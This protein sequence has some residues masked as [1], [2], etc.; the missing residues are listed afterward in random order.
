MF[1]LLLDFYEQAFSLIG[2]LTGQCISPH[3]WLFLP[4]L[5][6]LLNDDA[7]EYFTGSLGNSSNLKKLALKCGEGRLEM[8]TKFVSFLS[9]RY[10]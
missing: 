9:I 3:M 6:G 7:V 4:E 10:P 8:L 5:E 2:G 1:C